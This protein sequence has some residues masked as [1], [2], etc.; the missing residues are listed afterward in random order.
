MVTGMLPSTGAPAEA[1]VRVGGVGGPAH[2]FAV[3]STF[4]AHTSPSQQAVGVAVHPRLLVLQGACA[5]HP[6]GEPAA[7]EK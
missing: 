1:S 6:A 7:G 5:Q 3:P 2:T 4:R